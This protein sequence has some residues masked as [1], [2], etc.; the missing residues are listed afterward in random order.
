M[1]S[2]WCIHMQCQCYHIPA[3]LPPIFQQLQ[4]VYNIT[5]SLTRRRFILS[6]CCPLSKGLAQ[7]V[8]LSLTG[9]QSFVP[10]QNIWAH[11]LACT[12]TRGKSLATVTWGE[13]LSSVHCYV[14]FFHLWNHAHML[15]RTNT[16]SNCGRIL[17]LVSLADLKALLAKNLVSII[18]QSDTHSSVTGSTIHAKIS[19]V[20]V[21]LTFPILALNI[22]LSKHLKNIGSNPIQQSPS[23]F[24]HQ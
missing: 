1:W 18:L 15:E 24:K 19:L 6:H 16:P 7:A 10:Q 22:T 23:D 4:S 17:Q 9:L 12:C 20:P 5:Y 14:L 8:T 3:L 21:N 11:T 13:R 2:W